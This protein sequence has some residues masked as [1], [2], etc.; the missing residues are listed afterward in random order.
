MF[1]S[2]H[3]PAQSILLTQPQQKKLSQIVHADK[4]AAAIYAGI[5]READKALADPPKPIERIQTEGKLAKDPAKIKTEESLA[6]MRKLEVLGYAYAVEGDGEYAAK[7]REII[8]AWAKVNRSAGDPI[9]DTNLEPLLTAYDLA[10]AVFS[11]AE[12]QTVEAYLRGVAQAEI[13]SGQKKHDNSHNN[14]HSHRLKI[15]GLDRAMIARQSSH[16]PNRRALQRSDR[17]QS[18]CPRQLVRSSIESRRPA[19]P[20][21]RY[22]AAVDS[23]DRPRNSRVICMAIVPRGSVVPRQ[24]DFCSPSPKARRRTPIREPESWLRQK[25]G[26]RRPERVRSGGN[27]LRAVLGRDGTFARE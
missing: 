3:L 12:R 16:R 14:W 15:V 24:L 5:E 23:S 11:P 26:R 9:D 19:L 18:R 22:R 20:H 4:D 27:E 2:A 1:V 13:E 7:A 25:A 17:S 8:L 6:D 10:C 21:V